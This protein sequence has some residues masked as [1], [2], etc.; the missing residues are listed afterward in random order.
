MVHAAQ[1]LSFFSHSPY[2][3]PRVEIAR[4]STETVSSEG[5]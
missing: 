5:N 2:M 3:E 4:D 1:Q